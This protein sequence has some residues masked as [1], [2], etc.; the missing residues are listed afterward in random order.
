MTNATHDRDEPGPKTAARGAGEPPSNGRSL[1]EVASQE[2]EKKILTGQLLPGEKISLR[3]VANSIGMSMQPVRDAVNRFVAASALEITSNR[4]IRVP[5]LDRGAAEQIWAIRMLL[6][7]EAVRRFAERNRPEEV[8]PLFQFTRSLRCYRFG[9][10][11]EPT[12]ANS[13][14]WNVGLA[15]GSG[16][17]ILIDMISRMRLRFAP[18]LAYAYGLDKPHDEQFVTYTV[19]IMDELLLAIEAGDANAA[20]HVRCADIRSLKRYVFERIGW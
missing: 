9:V 8:R 1:V 20:V 10:D 16:S 7:G 2:I 11:L 14:A 19:Q 15:Q 18:I 5:A 3:G 6:E 13:M 4:T 17:P 12:M